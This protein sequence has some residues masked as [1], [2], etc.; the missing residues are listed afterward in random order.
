MLNDG[1]RDD[2]MGRTAPVNRSCL[3]HPVSLSPLSPQSPQVDLADLVAPSNLTSFAIPFLEF[4]P[5][6]IPAG[7][8]KWALVGN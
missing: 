3:V 5:G 4:L 6:L 2:I 8:R 1:T 7:Y